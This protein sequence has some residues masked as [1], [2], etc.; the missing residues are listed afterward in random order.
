[1]TTITRL[2]DVVIDGTAYP[3]YRDERGREVMQDLDI[4]RILDLAKP[5]NIKPTIEKY[6]DD[7]GEVFC[8]HQ[9]TSSVAGGRPGLAYYLTEEQALFIA[10][11]CR[12][13]AAA[14]QLK[15]LIAVYMA[16]RQGNGAAAVA[17]A[18]GGAAPAPLQSDDPLA[19]VLRQ[20]EQIGALAR[21]ALL[22]REELTRL[23]AAQTS[24]AVAVRQLEASH[25][26]AV[27]SLQ[28]FPVP[29]TPELPTISLRKTMNRIVRA[30]V[31]AFRL[32]FQAVWNACYSEASYRW[33]FDVKARARAR[34][35]TPMAVI[36]SDG[37]GE[38]M[39][40]V[41]THICRDSLKAAGIAA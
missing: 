14:A 37:L 16:A 18:Q 19:L 7:I 11:K 12:T 21:Q 26:A 41:V 36:E 28:T 32:N 17:I 27:A 29:P 20:S 39:L 6:S 25:Q 31:V 35:Q 22:Q 5:H 40:A 13:K 9:K 1:M 4:G 24:Q 8:Q 2:A 30:H 3:T 15:R 34:G 10:A 23:A 38:K 33:G